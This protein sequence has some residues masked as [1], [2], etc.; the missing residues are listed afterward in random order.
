MN[1]GPFRQ[2]PFLLLALILA[3]CGESDPSH[4]EKGPGISTDDE[5]RYLVVE[6]DNP[7]RISGRISLAAGIDDPADFSESSPE[8]ICRGA[9]DNRRLETGPDGG[10]AWGVVRL[11]D[12]PAGKPFPESLP[13]ID[14]EGCRYLPHVVTARVGGRVDFVNSDPISHNVRIEEESGLIL[15]NVA[16][17]TQGDV[18]P[19]DVST[20]GPLLV[21]CD[22]HPWMNAY[23]F[24]VENP[25][26]AVSRTD[27]SY[28]ITGV[29]PGAYELRMWLNGFDPIPRFDNNGRLVRY[30]YSDPFEVSRRIVVEEGGEVVEN[31]VIS[32]EPTEESE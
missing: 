5:L 4:E 27:G 20:A 7:G 2:F 19:F 15:M 12:V 31:F 17:P 26:V 25:Y 28:E 11:V 10:V 16:Q 13:R 18:D 8:D 22:Y 9:L 30:A 29:P 14:Q 1:G 6:V 23:V 3:A 24:G 21:G 32:E